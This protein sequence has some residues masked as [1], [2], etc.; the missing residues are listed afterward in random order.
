MWNIIEI[1]LAGLQ[2]PLLS[3]RDCK[4]R[5]AHSCFQQMRKNIPTSGTG[6]Y[7]A[8][9]LLGLDYEETETY[10]TDDVPIEE[11][12]FAD[13]ERSFIVYP[14]PAKDEVNISFLGYEQGE[15]ITIEVFDLT[16]KLSIYKQTNFT[17]SIIT[18]NTSE[19][20]SGIYIYRIYFSNSNGGNGKLIIGR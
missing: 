20:Q 1:V 3:G 19:L 2:I 11:Q 18:L 16:V 10:K 6:V 4:S 14:N 12:V 8:R 5:P 15:K 17:G 7:L 9:I 13:N